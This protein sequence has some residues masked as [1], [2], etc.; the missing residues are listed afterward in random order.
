MDRPTSGFKNVKPLSRH[1]R[2]ALKDKV[3]L[4]KNRLM[5]V[6]FPFQSWA[7]V[8]DSINLE[9]IEFRL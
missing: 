1:E 5:K 6:S 2:R 3:A 7:S 8:A 4:E 9:R